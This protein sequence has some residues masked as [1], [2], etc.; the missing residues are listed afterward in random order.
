M[1]C[2]TAKKINLKKRERLSYSKWQDWLVAASGPGKAKNRVLWP[3]FLL[4]YI[5]VPFVFKNFTYVK[6]DEESEETS[7]RIGKNI[8][9]LCSQNIS[10]TLTI[11]Q[12]KISNDK[13]FK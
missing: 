11:Q 3:Q 8:C 10:R 12:L 2:G 4:H 9:K 6:K 13:Q 5:N 7:D 1:Q